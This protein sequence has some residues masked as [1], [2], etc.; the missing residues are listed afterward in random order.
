ML[1]RKARV[2]EREGESVS[3]ERECVRERDRE[4]E[5]LGRDQRDRVREIESR[6]QI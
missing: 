3:G 5:K 6:R 4:R 1:G 2:C